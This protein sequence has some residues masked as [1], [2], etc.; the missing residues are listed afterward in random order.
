MYSFDPYS[1]PFLYFFLI[2]LS[3]S[4]WLFR[5]WRG[6]KKFKFKIVF[7]G[8]QITSQFKCSYLL[9]KKEIVHLFI[10]KEYWNKMADKF[11]ALMWYPYWNVSVE[12]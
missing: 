2:G 6:E 3:L 8:L 7:I 12:Q 11:N 10:C 1:R 5:P 4:Y 9:K